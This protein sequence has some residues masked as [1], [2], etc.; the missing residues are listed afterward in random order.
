M[1]VTEIIEA[2]EPSD[3]LDQN[4]WFAPWFR[5]EDNEIEKKMFRFV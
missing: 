4:G 2:T 3:I 5:I 1:A